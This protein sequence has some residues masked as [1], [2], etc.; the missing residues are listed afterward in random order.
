MWQ[1]L[2]LAANLLREVDSDDDQL[3]EEAGAFYYGAARVRGTHEYRALLIKTASETPGCYGWGQ[4][5]PAGRDLD[6]PG[7][8]PQAGSNL[9]SAV[10]CTTLCVGAKVT[11]GVQAVCRSGTGSEVRSAGGWCT[12]RPA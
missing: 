1:S 9:L 10:R 2:Y 6:Q 5:A 4:G 11:V 7:V 12:A 3:Y 8:H